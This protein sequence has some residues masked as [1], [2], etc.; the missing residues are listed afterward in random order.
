M[1]SLLSQFQM[2]EMFTITLLGHFALFFILNI[3]I[4]LVSILARHL[5]RFA[6]SQNYVQIS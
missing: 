6:L 1:M 5:R 4:D 2:V 3:Y